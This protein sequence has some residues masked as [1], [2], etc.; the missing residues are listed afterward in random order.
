MCRSI[1][2]W[3]A[4]VGKPKL[5]AEADD[6]QPIIDSIQVSMCLLQ[7]AVSHVAVVQ[8]DTSLAHTILQ[9]HTVLYRVDAADCQSLCGLACQQFL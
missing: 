4:E 1:A 9:E 8:Q 2:A 6:I 5:D 7:A 3:A